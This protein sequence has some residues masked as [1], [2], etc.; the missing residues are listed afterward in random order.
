M[1]GYRCRSGGKSM[2]IPDHRAARNQ[3]DTIY[4]S[5]CQQFPFKDSLL[6]AC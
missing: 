5:G 6:V 3:L 2:L 1:R 4:A